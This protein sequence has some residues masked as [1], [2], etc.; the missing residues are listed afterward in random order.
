MFNFVQRALD[1]VTMY[2]V[3]IY[4]LFAMVAHAFLLSFVELLPYTPLQ[5]IISFFLVT[6]TAYGVHMLCAKISRA[7][8]N[9][10]SSII[11]G[12]I[13]FL[14]LTPV[15]SMSTGLVTV[16]IVAG[17]VVFKYVLV[18]KHRHLFNPAALVIFIAG[19]FGYTGVEWW[20]G[21]RYML[22][23]VL[24]AGF[25]VIMK[26]RRSSIV[27]MY[28]VGSSVIA[29]LIFS[30][31]TTIVQAL[32]MHLISW[33]TIFFATI[34]LTEP[35][36]LPGNRRERYV[37]ALIV[38]A[39]SNYPFIF[40]P[41]HGTPEFGLLL[42]NLFTFLID[43][44]VRLVSRF[45]T[46]KEVG[47]GA[48][49]YIFTPDI[50]H[51]YV[52]GQYMEWTLP[53]EKPDVRGIRRYFTISSLPHTEHISFTVRHV[54]K[55]STWKAA[56]ERMQ[57]GDRIYA[58]QIAGDFTLDR[59]KHLVWIAGGIGI[60][61]F[62]AMLRDAKRSGKKLDATLFYCNK[63]EREIAYLDE[64]SESGS[65]CTTIHMLGE[66]PSRE[67]NYEIGFITKEILEKHVSNWREAT[68][69]ISGP[70]G[71]VDSYSSLLRSLGIPRSR[72]KTDYFPGLA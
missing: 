38:A 26:T 6:W 54:E 59:K 3:V 11:T 31:T 48:Y 15:S 72:I 29:A 13:L 18:Y 41:L 2:R 22:P 25:L 52:P 16:L 30:N 66:K 27:Y 40:G 62:I 21:S 46:R 10:E 56:L 1:G 55:Q 23:V 50:T 7:P 9:I 63:S 28:I 8:S 65:G 43:R 19:I 70:L 36:S 69:Y 51:S 71:L 60:T 4:A 45:V 58:T 39:A 17:A 24:L 37:Y 61:P 67:I 33:P 32:S 12:L 49:E 68:Y 53:H 34:M 44:P 57:P 64:V 14:I 47:G 35:L 42:G 5:L 20:V